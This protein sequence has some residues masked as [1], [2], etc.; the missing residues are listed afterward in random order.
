MSTFT[1]LTLLSLPDKKALA[2]KYVGSKLGELRTP[3]L[4][5]DRTL[6]TQNCERMAGKVKEKEMKFRV[7]V[8]SRYSTDLRSRPADA[9]AHKTVEGIRIQVQA[10]QGTAAVV[11]STM[12]EVWQIILSGMVEE[13]LI[14]DVSGSPY[15][16]Y[17]CSDDQIL[18][19]MPISADKLED[20]NDA[21]EKVSG[22]AVIRVM[23]D[24]PDQIDALQAFN[25]RMGRKAKWT[26]F[27]KV[28]GGGRWVMFAFHVGKATEHQTSWGTTRQPANAGSHQSLPGF[29]PGR[30]LW[31]LLS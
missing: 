20:L 10:G 9:L 15:S 31:L 28:D 23:V 21:Q 11:T 30:D 12:V 6:F 25:E 8:K 16:G 27:C 14:D 26:V 4:I 18:Y 2:D 29:V 7:H 24:H 19:S 17:Q 3:A 5:V 13:G 22:K 1:E